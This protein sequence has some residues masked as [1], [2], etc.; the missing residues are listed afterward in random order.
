MNP[1]PRPFV[2]LLAL[3]LL[4]LPATA[5]AAEP[6]SDLVPRLTLTGQPL[7]P[8]QSASPLLPSLS[9]PTAHHGA[10]A[11]DKAVPL[12]VDPGNDNYR[13]IVMTLSDGTQLATVYIF[14]VDLG[15]YV[16]GKE[17]WFINRNA[18]TN[19]GRY[20]M[21]ISVIDSN[22]NTPPG[23]P[24]Y[25]SEQAVA[26]SHLSNWGTGWTT[27]PYSTGQLF[28]GPSGDYLRIQT[29]AT[30]PPLID[31]V[32]WYQVLASGTPADID[33]AGS[34]TAEGDS[35]VSVPRGSTGYDISH[36]SG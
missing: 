36:I 7:A 34:W 22:S 28:A 9:S 25:T 27:D 3:S 35:S 10:G 11:S 12:E 13:A 15:T 18:L 21:S 6:G 14:N 32:I 1:I 4:A 30:S 16:T 24:G 26:P 29:L 33:P 20:G 31:G 2:S 17:Y 23:D 19:L 5:R 8:A